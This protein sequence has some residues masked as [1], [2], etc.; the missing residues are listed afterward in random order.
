MAQIAKRTYKLKVWRQ[1]G[2][3][4]PGHFEEI[5]AKDISPNG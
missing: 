4:E 3:D 5:L 1:N 2:P